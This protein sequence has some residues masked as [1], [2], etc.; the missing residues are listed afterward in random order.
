MSEGKLGRCTAPNW[1]NI[2]SI[3]TTDINNALI[4]LGSGIPQSLAWFGFFLF[5]CF[6]FCFV[7]FFVIHRNQFL[8]NLVKT[9]VD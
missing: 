6:L 8:K 7:L 4:F 5:A 3:D 9:N 1:S 2:K